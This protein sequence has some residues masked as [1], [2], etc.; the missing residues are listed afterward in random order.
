MLRIARYCYEKSSVCPTVRSSVCLSVCLWRVALSLATQVRT[1]NASRIISRLISPGNIGRRFKGGSKGWQGGPR[2]PVRGVL[3]PCPPNE[4]V[5]NV[6][7][8]HNTCIYSVASHSWCQLNYT[9]HSIMY[10]VI[11]N[12]SRTNR[13]SHT[14]LSAK[15]N[16][17]GWPKA[18]CF[19]THT[20]RCCYL[21][22]YSICFCTGNDYYRI[23]RPVLLRPWP[24]ETWS[25][26]QSKSNWV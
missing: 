10:Y 20:P 21:Q 7:G 5:C 23:A 26:W 6:A 14:R 22:F 8:L 11:R 3:P 12:S 17:L 25:I 16:D 19:K 13:M 18:L 2:P 24:I 15:I 4:T 1:W 9:I